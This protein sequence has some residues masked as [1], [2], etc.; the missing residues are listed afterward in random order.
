ME[1]FLNVLI[2]ICMMSIVLILDSPNRKKILEI[3]EMRRELERKL[4]K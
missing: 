4:N 1:H 2:F 3:L